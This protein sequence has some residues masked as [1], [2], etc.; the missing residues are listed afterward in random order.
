MT[1]DHGNGSLRRR[2]TPQRDI[3]HRCVVARPRDG[4]PLLLDPVSSMVWSHLEQ[5]RTGAQLAAHLR[6]AYP[7][8]TDEE[9][10][11]TLA[12]VVEMLASEGLVERRT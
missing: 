5:W 4:E 6:T 8:V 3:G 10:A 2:P 1:T 7:D 11:A 12:D 9:R